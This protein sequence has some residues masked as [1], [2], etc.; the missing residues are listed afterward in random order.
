M[1]PF[2]SFTH[3]QKDILQKYLPNYVSGNMLSVFPNRS[4]DLL[5]LS[6]FCLHHSGSKNCKLTP[7]MLPMIDAAWESFFEG[8]LQDVIFFVS[9]CSVSVG[10]RVGV[11][12]YIYVVCFILKTGH[13][14]N[15]CC[16]A[17]G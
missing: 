10:W 17:H 8:Y 6:E 15:V 12:G 1:G 4:L 11:A 3:T 13:Y 14:D 16:R 9:F 5:H 2:P 7:E